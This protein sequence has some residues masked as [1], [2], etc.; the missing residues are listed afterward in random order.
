MS[1]SI[2]SSTEK[3]TNFEELSNDNHLE[4]AHNKLNEDA[5]KSR[6]EESDKNIAKIRE[7]AKAEAEATSKVKVEQTHDT[8]SDSLVG[9]QSTLKSTAYNRT[10]AKIQLRLSK[11]SKSFSKVVHS[12]II[13]NV[14][15]ITAQTV[16]RPNGI[17]GGSV[18]A[19]VGSCV[20]LYFSKHYGFRYNY[21][22]AFGLF[23]VG[24]LL[25]SLIEIIVWTFYSRKHRY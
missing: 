1:E 17:L 15:N 7:M 10:L 19:F 2:K 14:S 24:Y 4:R 18:M 6:I 9:M 25:G 22:V 16:A 11:P 20:L 8:E 21:L 3:N 13:D 23:V 5:E 12:P